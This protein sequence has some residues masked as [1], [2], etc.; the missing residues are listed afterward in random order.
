MGNTRGGGNTRGDTACDMIL[1]PPAPPC[2]VPPGCEAGLLDCFPPLPVPPRRP[3]NRCQNHTDLSP[4][5]PIGHKSGP[6]SKPLG[7]KV[8]PERPLGSP[9]AT[10][11][12]SRATKMSP[13]VVHGSFLGHCVA[14]CVE[15]RGIHRPG[16]WSK[17]VSFDRGASFQAGF[18]SP[19]VASETPA[20]EKPL[21]GGNHGPPP[22]ISILA[23]PHR[24][25]L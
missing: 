6:Q 15:R 12:G 17:A 20:H 23:S 13:K 21:L 3:K 25:V 7:S 10:L 5:P 18:W 11:K 8:V 9:K 4:P 2:G 19:C 14:S 1:Y 24:N 16:F 22:I